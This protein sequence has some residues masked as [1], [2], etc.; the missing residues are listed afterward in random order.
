MTDAPSPTDPAPLVHET[1]VQVTPLIRRIVA[2]NPSHMTG[3]GT[4]TYV[5]GRA[6]GDLAVIDPGPDDR[7]HLD[8]I[9]SV[10]VDRI[11]W[12]LCTHT[13]P[14]HSPGAAA[15]KAAT[16]AEVMAWSN[17]GGLRTDRRIGDGFVLDGDGFTIEAV[18]TPGH[19]GNH[20]CFLLREEMVLFS[21][22]H[23]MQ[24]STVVITPPD[25]DMGAYLASLAKV[26][27]LRPRAIAPGHGHLIDDPDAI[28]DW[29]VNHRLERE[30][31][32]HSLLIEMESARIADLVEAAYVDLDPVLIP[33]A[34]RSVHAHL[35]KLADDG[36][37]SGTGARGTWHAPPRSN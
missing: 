34:K 13:H 36:H 14:D 8:A 24:G 22:D 31:Q 29:Y 33:M 26:R 19:A 4:N 12:I 21:G 9:E 23:I 17:R 15:L 7:T 16:G 11:R 30:A 32:L 3:K 2:N 35:R 20:L 1:A 25:G 5:V 37:V 6:D 10:G 28:I 18:H 27:A